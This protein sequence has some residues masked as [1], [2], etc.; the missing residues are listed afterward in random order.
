[1]L[2][3]MGGWQLVRSSAPQAAD[4]EPLV[5]AIWQYAVGQR[6]RVSL[7]FEEFFWCRIGDPVFVHGNRE[8]DFTKVGIITNLYNEDGEVPGPQAKRG[9]WAIKA[10]A[11]LYPNAPTLTGGS[12]LS[13]YES[14][15]S[16]AWIIRTMLPPKQRLAVAE[17]IREAMALNRDAIVASF[18]PILQESLTAAFAAIEKEL[19]KALASHQQQLQDLGAKYQQDLIEKEIIPLIKDEIFPI[20]Q[21][22]GQPVA[23]KVGQKI[24]KQMSLVSLGGRFL[25]DRLP[26]TKGDSLK[27]EWDRTLNKDVI[28]IIKAH[29]DDFVQMVKLIVQDAMKNEKVQQQMRNAFGRVVK[30]EQL[31]ALIWSVTK[32]AVV[33]NKTLHET[34]NAHWKSERAQAALDL[35]TAKI[36]PVVIELGNM[37]F[38]TR[39]QGITPQFSA[40]M[41]NRV[42]LKDRQWFILET[43]GGRAETSAA[44]NQK[45]R[46]L[47]VFT[48]VG[49]DNP[50]IPAISLDADSNT[51]GKKV[52]QN[53]E[54]GADESK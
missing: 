7:D 24:W 39:E 5:P 34:I 29:S 37:L 45:N 48:G 28:P 2:I 35:A 44:S 54:V 47:K 15:D 9:A 17:K 33:E 3:G 20:A 32:Q 52:M 21:K 4:T 31:H 16:V 40:V 42:L 51:S 12:A 19:P 27:K 11:T 26:G 14:E 50:Y 25:W 43:L 6:T 8:D 36:E 23:D 18:R 30:D 46:T 1:M 41:R 10:R 49:S 38:G 13:Y 22:H 53:A